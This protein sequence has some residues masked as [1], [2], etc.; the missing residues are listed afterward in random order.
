MLHVRLDAAT[1][2]PDSAPRA[3][4]CARTWRTHR[5]C[6]RFFMVVLFIKPCVL[7]SDCISMTG[8][9]TP[10]LIALPACVSSP[11]CFVSS[12]HQAGGRRGD[13]AA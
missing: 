4:M 8:V 9:D 3:N 13:E 12:G 7:A 1:T 11:S 2:T 5:S 6:I 10:V